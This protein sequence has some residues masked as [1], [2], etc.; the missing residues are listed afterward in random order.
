M[1]VTLHRRETQGEPQRRICRMLARVAD[2]GDV[3]IVF[4]VHLSPA[5]RHGV[6][7]ELG[8]SRNLR[9]LPP[10]DYVTFVELMRTSDLVVT[11]SGG[12]QEEAPSL[13]VPVVVLR[14][15]TDRPE[16]VRAGCAVLAGTDPRRASFHINRILDDPEAVSKVP[17]NPYGD[18]RAAERIVERLG[19]ELDGGSSSPTNRFARP[20]KTEFVP[21]EASA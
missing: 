1:L 16:S 9:L 6:Q 21:V 2:R 5:V 11:D 13:G 4:P 10:V 15:T 20:G 12:V 19:F 18:G 14:D 3:E 7:A 17:R 8:G